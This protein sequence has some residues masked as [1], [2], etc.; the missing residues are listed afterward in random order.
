MDLRIGHIDNAIIAN[1]NGVDISNVVDYKVT[2]SAH[3]GTEVE[4]KIKLDDSIT[5][6]ASSTN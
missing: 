1:I 5:E 4:L 2:T 3:D 6:L